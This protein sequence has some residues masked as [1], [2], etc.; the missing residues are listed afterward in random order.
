MHSYAQGNVGDFAFKPTADGF[1]WE[2]HAGPF[3][4]RYTAMI[5]D[6]TWHEVGDRIMPG[7]DPVR[8]FDMN[9]KRLG[10]TSWPAAGAVSPK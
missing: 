1:V 10:D 5:K 9:L 8:I 4:I 3:T 2:I 6:G 7:K